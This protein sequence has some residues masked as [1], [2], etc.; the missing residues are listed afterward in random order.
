MYKFEHPEFVWLLL[1]VPATLMLF[2]LYRLWQKRAQDRFGELLPTMA[3]GVNRTR[4]FFK[5][6]LVIAAFGFLALSLM[7][8]KVGTKM[9]TV[10]RKGIDVVFALDVSKSMLAEDVAPNRLQKAKFL[11]GK[12]IDNLKGDRLGLII[13]AGSAYPLLPITTDYG[14]AKLKL[15]LASP[16]LVPSMGT[17]LGD[18]LKFSQQFYNDE[19]QK[20][21][22]LVILSDGE[23]HEESWEQ[24]AAQLKEQGVQVV[25]IGIGTSKGGPIPLKDSR[26][27]IKGYKKDYNNEVV[28]TK[29]DASTLSEIAKSTDGIY[30]DGNDA[31]AAIDELTAK[32]EGMEKT[33]FEAQQISD[34]QDQFQWFLGVALFLLILDV[35]IGEKKTFWMEKIG[36][37]K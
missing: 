23:D 2:A 8:L 34:Y 11:T 13:Y 1:L 37:K 3:W 25:T 31:V 20:N 5:T 16:D 27:N 29:R 22:L 28:V 32:I 7:N 18:V 35:F 14:T 4:P 17:A 33:E 24:E 6:F 9:E 19:S 15:D 10:K 30:I 12:I 36:L 21:R 26:G